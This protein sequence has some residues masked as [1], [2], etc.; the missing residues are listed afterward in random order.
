LKESK[1]NWGNLTKDLKTYEDVQKI[2]VDNIS[3]YLTLPE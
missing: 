1:P 3:N 2:S